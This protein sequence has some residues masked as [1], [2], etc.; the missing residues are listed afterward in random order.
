[1]ELPEKIQNK[2]AV[3]NPQ[4]KTDNK[5][6]IWCLLM[7]KYYDKLKTHKKCQ[8]E[9]YNK[10]LNEIIEPQGQEYPINIQKDIPKFEKFNDIK[11]VVFTLDDKL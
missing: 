6:L 10:Y 11:I 9:Y 1:M 5:C 3:V 8:V 2:K 4:N 7:V